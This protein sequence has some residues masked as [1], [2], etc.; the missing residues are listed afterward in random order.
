MRVLGIDPGTVATGWGVVETAASRPGLGSRHCRVASGVIRARGPLPER[1]ATIFAAVCAIL[2]EH[3]PAALSIEKTFVSENVQ[4][5]FR[6][7][8]ARGSILVAAARAGV[9]IHEYSPAEIKMAVVGYGR[10][11]K[12]QVQSMVTRLLSLPDCPATDEADALAAA[13]CH[14]QAHRIEK[15]AGGEVRRLRG[16][17]R[18]PSAP[19]ALQLGVRRVPR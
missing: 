12:D 16:R 18:R 2:E 3:Q 7:G 11:V 5:A 10:A 1:L 4:T 9:T 14:L 13:L 6:L 8:E 19:P 17:P 15:L